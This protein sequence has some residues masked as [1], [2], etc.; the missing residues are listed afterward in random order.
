M[1]P[2][3]LR[4]AGS[5]VQPPPMLLHLPRDLVPKWCCCFLKLQ[6][7][8][9]AGGMHVR[10]EGKQTPANTSLEQTHSALGWG[11][12]ISHLDTECPSPQKAFWGPT[13]ELRMFAGPSLLAT[14]P[15]CTLG[16]S[17]SGWGTHYPG[18]LRL[19]AASQWDLAHVPLEDWWMLRLCNPSWGIH[20]SI[21]WGFIHSFTHV[22]TKTSLYEG[23]IMYQAG[24]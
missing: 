10:P 14:A 18:V 17:H 2:H 12:G 22:C 5:C 15:V 7:S 4:R 21:R 16:T 1:V 9:Q 20:R 3:F 13:S 23:L 8:K 11:Q 24:G 6:L 19:V